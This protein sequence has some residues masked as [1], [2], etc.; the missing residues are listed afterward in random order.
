[1]PW[2]RLRIIKDERW[3]PEFSVGG[4]VREGNKHLR[5]ETIFLAGSK[6]FPIASEL[7]REVRLHAGFRQF[8]QARDV[9]PGDASIVYAGGELALPKY[10]FALAEIS[11][12][13]DAFPHTPFAFGLQARIPE[14]YGFSL[15]GIQSGNDDGIGVYIGIGV[16]F[17]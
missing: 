12:R 9:N 1:G 7:L 4:I 17:L 16:N 14:G 5:R 10:L 6:G 13:S 2:L 11:N 15:A 8:W 3:W